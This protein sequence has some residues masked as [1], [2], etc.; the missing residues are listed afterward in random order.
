MSTYSSNLRIE[1]PTN[2]T[3]AGVWGDTTNNN[4]AYILESAISGYQV[5]TVSSANQALTYTNGPT[6][7][8][9]GNQ[10]VYSALQFSSYGSPF[11]I[12][13]PPVSKMYLIWNN[14]GQ[15]MTLCNSTVIGNT[16][17]AGTGTSYVVNI[18]YN[19]VS[20]GST[21]LAEWQIFNRDLTGIPTVGQTIYATSTNTLAGGATIAA[22]V[23]I[24]NGSKSFV[25]TN[26]T[27]FFDVQGAGVVP[28]TSGGTG[29][30]TATAGFNAL[31]PSQGGG[32]LG[33]YLKSNG[34]S[35]TA[36]SWTS[37]DLN[38]TSSVTSTLRVSNGG[39]GQASNLTQ[40]GVVYGSTTTA[41]ATTSAGSA[42][43]VL[44]GNASG[45]PTWGSVS[46]A[47]DVTGTLGIGS[48][49][50]GLTSTGTAGN[51]LTS[52]GGVWVSSPAIGGATNGIFWEND[53]TV[54]TDYTITSTKN[55][56]TFG[57]ITIGTGVT[58][59]VPDPSTWTIV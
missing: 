54:T 44:H 13:A 49:G 39:T 37:I 1:L 43:Q 53:L 22:V 41:M 9:S 18:A 57:P 59:T 20:L 7:T 33:K 4:L 55:A 11:I 47:N 17:I 16:T 35:L 34:S 56:G 14:S 23:S 36:T 46:L 30:I 10:A 26:G 2:G 32:T 6:S 40:Y 25:W 38:D 19:V 27:N 12:Y 31:A 58:V 52:S 8:A 42:T 28:I 24:A 21:S 5:V 45:A 50:T 48:G 51:V 3:Q 15:S 29:Q